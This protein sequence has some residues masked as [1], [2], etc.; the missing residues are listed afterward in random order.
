MKQL[1][2]ILLVCFATEAQ[3]ETADP[4]LDRL[5]D[6]LTGTFSSQAQSTADSNFFDIRLIMTDI[7]TGRDDGYWLYVEQAT[8]V[9]PDKPDRQ[10]I[11]HLHRRDD[12]TLVS[13]VYT[14][15]EPLRFAGHWVRDDFPSPLTPDSLELRTGCTILL[16]AVNDTLFVGG[17][18]GER[19]ESNLRGASYAASEVRITPNV[20][21][22]WDRGYDSAGVQV[23]GARTGGYR[24]DKMTDL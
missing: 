10:R 9:T 22:S 21:L 19:C 2:I 24:F 4:A 13:D 16:R 5:H 3:S 11:Y 7:W 20:L 17:T 6:Y 18:E 1:L 12:S 14:F 8:A 23:W 15:T